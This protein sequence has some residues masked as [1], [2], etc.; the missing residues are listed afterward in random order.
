MAG[1]HRDQGHDFL[2]PALAWPP[3]YERVGHTWV[4]AQHLLDLFDEHLFSAGVDDLGIA[5]EQSEGAVIPDGCPVAGYY[6]ALA[7]DLRESPLGGFRIVV[8]P[9]WNPARSSN[10]ADFLLS[11]SQEPAAVSGHHGYPFPE[12]E[13]VADDS[14][15]AVSE[16]RVAR[17][18]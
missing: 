1:L 4:C 5:T 7:V 15:S 10:P 17:F 13:S 16:C 6:D 12:F 8:V 9:E 2:A 14:M 3:D 11:G 18:R